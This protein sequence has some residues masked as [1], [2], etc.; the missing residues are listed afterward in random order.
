MAGWLTADLPGAFASGLERNPL[1][2]VV[3]EPEAAHPRG[4]VS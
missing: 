1:S 3:M 4:T 2:S